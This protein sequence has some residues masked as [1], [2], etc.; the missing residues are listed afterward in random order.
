MT[1]N[2]NIMGLLSNLFKRKKGKGL[3]TETQDIDPH[4]AEEQ[5]KSAPVAGSTLRKSTIKALGGT[6]GGPK[7][8]CADDQEDEEDYVPTI[9][10]VHSLRGLQKSDRKW[11]AHAGVSDEVVAA[12]FP[13]VIHIINFLRKKDSIYY[14][15]IEQP[16]CL[17]D[18]FFTLPKIDGVI[19]SVIVSSVNN[20][21]SSPLPNSPVFSSSEQCSDGHESSAPTK[22]RSSS[23]NGSGINHSPFLRAMP[24]AS[25]SSSSG[26]IVTSTPPASYSMSGVYPERKRRI[27]AYRIFCA[28][29]VFFKFPEELELATEKL[30]I[31]GNP[32]ESFK[33]LDFEAKGGFGSVFAAKNKNPHSN[34][35]RHMVA[36]KK[37]PHRT[38]KQRRMNMSEIGFMRFCRHPNIVQFLCSYQRGDELW[39]IM[40]FMEGGTL[41]EAI[42]NFNFCE[43][44]IAYVARE[45]LKGIDYLHTNG[46]CHRDLKSSNIMISMK[47][48]IKII[49]FGLA[50]DFNMERE[51]VHMC[52]SPFWMPP[53]QIQGAAHSFSAD[54]WSFGVCIAEM[55]KRK[56][57]NHSSRL[58][59][60]VAVATEGLSFTREEYP[61]WSDDALD[62][63]SKCLRMEPSER[64]T[65]TVLLT[66]PFLAKACSLKDIRDI[67][68]ALFMSNTLSK[69]GL[70]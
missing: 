13:T 63:L 30:L 9:Y 2:R 15:F 60:M 46:L 69:Q 26:V 19:P 41:R 10:C 58:K 20:G 35:D 37:M 51:D 29:G 70:F 62:F 34:H 48:D 6:G 24:P 4:H 65:T 25:M 31:E 8:E 67:L 12:N 57:P 17:K 11:L 23:T 43:A 38:P 32:K 36:L 52:G 50:I 59:A 1:E 3:L 54:I 68:P 28:P 56:V 39:M 5:P 44:R 42:A 14:R 21:S 33:N 49:D 7:R 27:D 66:H 53:E 16:D 61:E 22:R 47:G 18:Q 64:A 45:V 40:E 55:L